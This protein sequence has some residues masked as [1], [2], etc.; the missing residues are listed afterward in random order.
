MR[1]I[2]AS[3]DVAQSGFGEPARERVVR[4]D[5][6]V[7]RWGACIG[8][9]WSVDVALGKGDGFAAALRLMEFCF[10]FQ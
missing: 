9:F 2:Y 8:R 10:L 6:R 1:G 3:G 7:H 5:G 4:R